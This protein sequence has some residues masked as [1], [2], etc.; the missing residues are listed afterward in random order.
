M[1]GT[2]PPV[3]GILR[4]VDTLAGNTNMYGGFI[5]D[6]EQLPHEPEQFAARLD[7]SLT[8]W[9]ESGCR[10]VWLELPHYAAAL[11][12][13]AV[14]VGFAYHHAEPGMLMMTLQLQAEASIPHYATHNV[15]GGGVVIDDRRRLLVVNERYRRDRSKPYYKLPGGSLDP[16]E[17]L[18]EAVVREVAEETGVQSEFRGVVSIR[19]RHQFRFGRSDFYIVCRL[20]P[21][22]SEL[23]ADPRE[24]EECLWMPVDEYFTSPYTGLFNRT[25][26]RQAL[27]DAAL[28]PVRIEDPQDYEFFGPADSGFAAPA[29]VQRREAR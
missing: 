7:N 21:L 6:P 2:P 13:I 3:A 11:V 25:I 28:V 12:P 15:G 16:Q 17:D 26:V 24:I 22:T 1:H 8:A 4:A 27:A 18:A 9:R 14:S 23:R 29:D 19:H 20:R 5:V 10:L